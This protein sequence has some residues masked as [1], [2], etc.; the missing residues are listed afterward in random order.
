MVP[1]S[2][3]WSAKY[4]VE[5]LSSA[6]SCCTPTWHVFRPVHL[7]ELHLVSV[8]RPLN[9]AACSSAPA[10][11]G[12]LWTYPVRPARPGRLGYV[13]VMLRGIK[14]QRA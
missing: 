13:S 3:D 14:A 11:A 9:S 1:D 6:I 5:D 8:L 10:C 2:E 7:V 12:A 4:V